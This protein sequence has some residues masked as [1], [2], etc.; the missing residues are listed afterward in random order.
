MKS[1]PA[2]VKFYYTA[3][4]YDR[5]FLEKCWFNIAYQ[6]FNKPALLIV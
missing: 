2:D 3:F 4:N 5:F 6:S 1:E